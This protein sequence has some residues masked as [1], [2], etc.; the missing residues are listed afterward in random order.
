MARRGRERLVAVLERG[1]RGRRPDRH[2]AVGARDAVQ[3]CPPRAAAPSSGRSRPAARSGITIVPPPTTVTPPPSP[4]AAIASS[5]EAG[6]RTSTSASG[7]A[8]IYTRLDA[9][10]SSSIG[11][12]RRATG[13]RTAGARPGARRERAE[14]AE[15]RLG[16]EARARS[17]GVEPRQRS[18]ISGGGVGLGGDVVLE[19][20]RA[21]EVGVP[22]HRREQPFRVEPLGDRGQARARRRRGASSVGSVR[23]RSSSH[24]TGPQRRTASASAGSAT[25][26]SPSAAA[27]RSKPSRANR[28]KRP[29]AAADGDARAGPQPGGRPRRPRRGSGSPGVGNRDDAGQALDVVG[30]GAVVP[31]DRRRERA[32]PPA[33]CRSRRG[34]GRAGSRARGAPR[35]GVRRVPGRCGRPRARASQ[36]RSRAQASRPARIERALQRVPAG[37]GDRRA[38]VCLRDPGGRRAWARSRTRRAA[39]PPCATD[40]ATG[41]GTSG[42]ASRCRPPPRRRCTSR[43]RGPG[44]RRCGT[45]SR[46]RPTRERPGARARDCAAS[47]GRARS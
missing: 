24:S 4:K 1:E 20:R 21:A 37:E 22:L 40:T 35:G 28:A 12:G 9:P 36:P 38:G 25:S 42:R 32:R 29:G 30:G 46:G 31:D 18:A 15:E 44:S 13:R 10:E 23:R 3:A 34:R 43:R 8:S 26:S 39:R 14:T 45:R 2:L 11:G 7:I 47:S 33:S 6:V 16:R 19:A 27:S 41:R 5:A 17:V